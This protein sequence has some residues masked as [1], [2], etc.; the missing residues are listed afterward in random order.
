[1]KVWIHQVANISTRLQTYPPGWKHIHQVANISTRLQTY[2]PGCKHI[3]QVANIST[4]LQTYPNFKIR[5]CGKCSV[6]YYKIIN[7][8]FAQVPA[9][10]LWPRISSNLDFCKVWEHRFI[11]VL[12]RNS[13]HFF[14]S[15]YIYNKLRN[16]WKHIR[17]QLYAEFTLVWRAA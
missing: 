7:I 3:H 13:K 10:T 5:V 17:I 16:D 14:S 8:K 15:R 12:I 6:P 11:R 4:R 9:T 2:P 1:M